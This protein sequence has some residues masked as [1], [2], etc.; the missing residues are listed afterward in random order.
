VVIAVIIVPE[1]QAAFVKVIDVIAVR[2]SLVAAIA[3]MATAVGFL[4]SS[5]I[6]R[7]YFDCMFVIVIV[8]LE[9]QVAVVKIV[10]VTVVFNARMAAT[11]VV[12]VRMRRMY[13]MLRHNCS[14]PKTWA[15][16]S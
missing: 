4:A 10:S 15:V 12:T 11:L 1:V 5:W 9:M 6:G 2:D 16:C 3:V 14:F 7:R 8:V 13:V